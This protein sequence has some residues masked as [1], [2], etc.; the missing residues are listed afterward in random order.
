MRKIKA[1]GTIGYIY[2]TTMGFTRTDNEDDC[3]WRQVDPNYRIFVLL[4]TK[5]T[6]IKP[7]SHKR[8][9]GGYALF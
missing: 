9:D 7:L 3:G 8:E 6:N 4:K 1:S 5:P 2:T